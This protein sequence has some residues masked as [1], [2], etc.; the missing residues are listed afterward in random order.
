M[1]KELVYLAGFI[2]A[3]GCVTVN[4]SKRGNKIYFGAVVGISGTRREPHDLA[5]ARW[6][7]KV[8]CWIPKNPLH[9]P[10]FQWARQGLS[11]VKVLR[12]IEP[13]LLLKQTQAQLA[14]SLH[15][16][17]PIAPEKQRIAERVFALNQDRRGKS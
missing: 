9:R 14:I 15:E 13:Y 6:G 4:R 3:D 2:D 11:A 8:W 10:Q 17:S 7:G 1:D 16:D 12:Q 5:A